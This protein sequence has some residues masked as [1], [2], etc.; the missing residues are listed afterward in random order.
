MKDL[1]Y[2]GVKT[3]YFA[4]NKVTGEKESFPDK[5]VRDFSIKGGTHSEPSDKKTTSRL[6]EIVKNI[7]WI[8]SNYI[9]DNEKAL[10]AVD[11][12]IAANP[13][14]ASLLLAKAKIYF[15]Q[16]F[17]NNFYYCGTLYC[18]RF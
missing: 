10:V 16:H 15:L 14:D 4:K 6:P 7:S 13:E 1:N 18:S 2:T 5:T 17:N 8:Y 12:A 9:G 3:Q 11:E